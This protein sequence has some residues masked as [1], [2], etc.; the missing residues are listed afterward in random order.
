[1]AHFGGGLEVVLGA[2]ELEAVGVG[3]EGAGLHAQEGVVG[4]RVLTVGVM[5]VVGGEERRV[6]APGDLN[7]LWIR[8]VLVGDPVV[9]QLDEEVV[10]AEDVL[11]AGC[12]LLGP[13]DVARQQR[14]QHHAAQAPVVAIRPVW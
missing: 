1:M 2:I 13:L 9:L 14:L 3:E 8:P 5:A 7:Q 4:D 11:Q 6:N 10:P 12:L